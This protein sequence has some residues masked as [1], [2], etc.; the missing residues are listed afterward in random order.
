MTEK[1]YPCDL[2]LS[3]IDCIQTALS[4][5]EKEWRLMPR[6]YEFETFTSQTIER[7]Q[8]G[9]RI[10]HSPSPAEGCQATKGKGMKC[11]LCLCVASCEAAHLIWIVKLPHGNEYICVTCMD[12]LRKFLS[13]SPAERPNG[14]EESKEADTTPPKCY[15]DLI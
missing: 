3:E 5:L 1:V 9:L 15:G 11:K 4:V 10:A 2:T 12:A 6:L 14:A 8:K 13:P 7:L